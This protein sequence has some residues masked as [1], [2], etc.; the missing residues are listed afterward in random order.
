MLSR[1]RA[2]V[3]ACACMALMSLAGGGGAM[4]Q[5]KG[6]HVDPDSPSGKE[7]KLPLE[8]ARRDAAPGLGSGHGGGGKPPLFGTGISKGGMSGTKAPPAGDRTSGA[9]IRKIHRESGS[10]A[11]A[12]DRSEIGRPEA[13]G[14]DGLSPGI[15]TALM[16]LG[17][18]LVGGIVG[19]SLR[20]MR[21]R[22][23]PT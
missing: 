16:A 22:H 8:D 7:Y 11:S 3:A 12:T 15:L 1:P 21:G 5:E 19:V 23:Q 13:G 2:S 14:G 6:A 20:A 18:L 10:T 9:G 17:V 4:A